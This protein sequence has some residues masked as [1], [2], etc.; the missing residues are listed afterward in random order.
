[1]NSRDEHVVT[2]ALMVAEGKAGNM[3]HV[4]RVEISQLASKL[5]EFTMKWMSLIEYSSENI[6]FCC[7]CFQ[8]L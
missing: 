7:F 2:D 3:Q 8:Q 1:M 5:I 6:H 4:K